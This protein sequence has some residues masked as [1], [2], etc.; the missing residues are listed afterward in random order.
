VLGLPQVTLQWRDCVSG[1]HTA[2]RAQTIQLEM[3]CVKGIGKDHAKWSPVATAWY[4]LKP[5][6]TVL[7]VT[8]AASAPLL[9]T[10]LAVDCQAGIPEP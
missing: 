2:H 3:H 8:Q 9:A 1:V 5:E 7:K 4:Q 10:T 6:V